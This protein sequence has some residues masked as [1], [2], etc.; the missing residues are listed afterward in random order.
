MPSFC[1]VCHQQLHVFSTLFNSNLQLCHIKIELAQKKY[2]SGE[3]HSVFRFC[4][5]RRRRRECSKFFITVARYLHKQLVLISN[6]YNAI[7]PL[8]AI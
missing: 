5:R 6:E 2:I 1:H 4:G 7:F 3:R 8:G